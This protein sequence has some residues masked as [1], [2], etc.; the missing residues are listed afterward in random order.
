SQSTKDCR[1]MER[2]FGSFHRVIPLPDGI[3][4]DRAQAEFKKGVLTVTLPKTKEV[5]AVGNKVPIKAEK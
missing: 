5:Q 3:D 2:S 1:V 4:S